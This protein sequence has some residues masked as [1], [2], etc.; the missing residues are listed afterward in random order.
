LAG[1]AGIAASAPLIARATI[2]RAEEAKEAE[3]PTEEEVSPAE[4][5]MR[6]HGVLDRVL[7]IYDEVVGR[8]ETKADF[9]P[10]VLSDSTGIIRR[11]IEDYHEKLEEDQLFPRFERAHTLV[12]LV[13][14]LR[15]QHKAGRSL[16]DA[17][18][19]LATRATLASAEN[20]AKL[21]ATLRRFNRMYRPHAAREDTVLFPALHRIV[22]Q[23]EYDSLGEEFEDREHELFGDDGFEKVV[24]QVAGL[25]RRLGIE[26]LAS[27]TPKV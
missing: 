10:A 7:L 8:L 3:E 15:E 19:A 20:R 1:G 21:A 24:D 22:S 16:T 5:L 14:V 26:D 9:D 4:D 6:E 27:F 12:D 11:F 18:H 25:E 17:I 13:G 2:S 23:H